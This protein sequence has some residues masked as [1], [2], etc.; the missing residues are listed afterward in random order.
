M[1][2]QV[3]DRILELTKD[4]IRE[5]SPEQF[6]DGDFLPASQQGHKAKAVGNPPLCRSGQRIS[7]LNIHR[8]TQG[9]L[10]ARG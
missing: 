8:Y 1:V 7:I 6:A 5:L 4:G 2:T 10:P 9:C 3:A